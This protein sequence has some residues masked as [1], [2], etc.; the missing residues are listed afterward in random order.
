MPRRLG[1]YILDEVIGRGGMGEVWRGRTVEGRGPSLAI[2]LLRRDLAEQEDLVARLLLERSILVR[3][4]SAYIVQVHDLVAEGGDL[5]IVMDLV[6]GSDLRHQL[7]DRGTL[8][9]AEVV[10]LGAEILQ[11]AAVAH[12][13]GVV[14]RDLKPENVLLAVAPDGTAQARVTDFGIARLTDSSTRLTETSA[15]LGTPDYM[16]PEMIESGEVGPPTDLY[17]CGILLYE[18]LCGVTPYANRPGLAVLRAHVDL[19]P[20]RPASVPNELWWVLTDM[21]SKDPRQRPAATAAAD[22]LAALTYQMRAIPAAAGLATPPPPYSRGSRWSSASAPAGP[23]PGEL[24]PPPAAWPVAASPKAPARAPRDAGA[25]PSG[26][27]APGHVPPRRR[28]KVS[29][30]LVA[31][32][33][34]AVLM[35]CWTVVGLVH[36]YRGDG[37]PNGT[38]LAANSGSPTPSAPGTRNGDTVRFLADEDA[39]GSDVE[40]WLH[41]PA[42]V[43]GQSLPRS[44]LLT[45]CNP[46]EWACDPS[47]QTGSVSYDLGRH[48]RRFQA[49]AGLADDAADNAIYRIEVYGDGRKLGSQQVGLGEVFPI[50]VDVTGILRLRLQVANLNDQEGNYMARLQSDVVFGDARVTGKKSDV[51]AE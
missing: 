26:H 36:H 10:R 1:G 42:S 23:A 7:R 6:N 29:G 39:V 3:L 15:V 51:P 46:S 38:G 27:R 11:A 25:R 48:F 9:P 24:V 45:L 8:P 32:I 28:G 43:N 19:E 17:S 5:G 50:D 4:Q 12:A 35:A 21:L 20:G 31:A 14:H 18:L 30:R 33:V 44:V 2:K 22:A 16:A 37:H 47:E 41:G 34:M 49:T 40:Y 13:A